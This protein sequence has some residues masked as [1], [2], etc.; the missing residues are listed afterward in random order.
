MKENSSATRTAVAA[1]VAACS[2]TLSVGITT[3]AL[4]GYLGRGTHERPTGAPSAGAL[5][6]SVPAGSPGVVLVPVRPALEAP[7]AGFREGVP[8]GVR[9]ASLRE[10]DRDD[11]HEQEAEPRDD[12]EDDD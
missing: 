9:R 10:H 8:E 7:R 5:T 2:L 6:G 3:A 11:V 1:A 12:H 4:L